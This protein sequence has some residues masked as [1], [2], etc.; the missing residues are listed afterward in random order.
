MDFF[1]VNLYVAIRIRV[2]RT[3]WT[4]A[5]TVHGELFV[6][7]HFSKKAVVN[8]P[9]VLVEKFEQPLC[10]HSSL[11]VCNSNQGHYTATCLINA[12][13]G[14]VDMGDENLVFPRDLVDE[15][16]FGS[17]AFIKHS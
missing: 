9:R 17:S 13:T 14:K 6:Y 2:T 8:V 1:C 16:G 5:K 7:I 10:S 12:V 15:K 11:G 3:Y 4:K